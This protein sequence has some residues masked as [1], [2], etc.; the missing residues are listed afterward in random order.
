MVSRCAVCLVWHSRQ[1]GSAVIV[2]TDAG[3]IT[4]VTRGDVWA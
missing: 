3:A 2:R 4:Y 1:S